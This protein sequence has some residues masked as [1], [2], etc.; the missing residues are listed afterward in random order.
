M[1]RPIPVCT[2]IKNIDANL[3]FQIAVNCGSKTAAIANVHEIK[4]DFITSFSSKPTSKSADM[5][6]KKLQI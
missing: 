4:A 6:R 1:N 5:S 3:T 2:S